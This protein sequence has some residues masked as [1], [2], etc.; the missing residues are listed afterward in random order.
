MIFIVMKISRSHLI[1][2]SKSRMVR[3]QGTWFMVVS[4]AVYIIYQGLKRDGR[5]GGN[6]QFSQ[7]LHTWRASSMHP[8]AFRTNF[9]PYITPITKEIQ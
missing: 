6:G 8:E 5:R 7:Y 3:F 2:E 1:I 9:L 4:P